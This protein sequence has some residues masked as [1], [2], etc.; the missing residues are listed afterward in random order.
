MAFYLGLRLVSRDLP[1]LQALGNRLNGDSSLANPNDNGPERFVKVKKFFQ[2]H[3]IHKDRAL[4]EAIKAIGV[5]LYIRN[6]LC[7]FK[8]R[9]LIISH[10]SR[11]INNLLYS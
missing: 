2:D 5:D 10:Q 3:M 1:R 9:S 4:N 7:M 11:Q 8:K 6:N